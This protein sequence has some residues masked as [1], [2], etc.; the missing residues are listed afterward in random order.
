MK[1]L[2]S[3]CLY[4]EK[5]DMELLS[6]YRRLIMECDKIYLPDILQRVS[7]TPCSRFWVSEQRVSIVLS[8]MFKGKDVLKKM[9]MCKQDM[10]M[11]LF[12]RALYLKYKEPD[13][14]LSSIAWEVANQSSPK[15]YLDPMCIKVY[16]HYIKKL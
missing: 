13:R 8:S 2:G 6:A 9:R 10:F 12:Q 14:T 1:K 15:F 7:D 16:L 4:S 5:R 11:K 3:K